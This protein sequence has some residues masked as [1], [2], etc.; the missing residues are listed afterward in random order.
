MANAGL[1]D[2]RTAGVVWLV[3]GRVEALEICKGH[4]KRGQTVNG[5]RGEAIGGWERAGRMRKRKRIG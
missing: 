3:L 1:E 5:Q 4:N 2:G